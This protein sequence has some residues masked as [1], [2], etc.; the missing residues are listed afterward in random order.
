MILGF[1]TDMRQA[2]RQAAV[3]AQK[4]SGNFIGRNRDLATPI[5]EDVSSPI[6]FLL[7]AIGP[8][9]SA[10]DALRGDRGDCPNV[11]ANSVTA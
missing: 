4:I 6:Q 10:A 5:S 11:E 9:R 7:R 2:V 8:R 1:H 3:T